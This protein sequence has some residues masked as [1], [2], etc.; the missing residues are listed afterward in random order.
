MGVGE[1]PVPYGAADRGPPGGGRGA[2]LLLGEGVLGGLPHR[3]V[4]VHDEGGQQVVPAGEVPVE[5]GR[6][7]AQLAGDG[8][9]RELGGAVRRQLS[10]GL[11]LDGRGDFDACPC[12]GSLDGAHGSSLPV[13]RAVTKNATGAHK[14]EQQTLM[15]SLLLLWIIASVQT[16]HEREHRSLSLQ[17]DTPCPLPPTSRSPAGSRSTS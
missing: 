6:N 5:G 15:R 14:R 2:G 11:V 1:R 12:A 3:V 16:A 9:E 4:G 13:R 10:P 8:A 17:G 7:H